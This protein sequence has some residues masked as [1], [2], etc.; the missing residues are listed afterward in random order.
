M[1]QNVQQQNQQPQAQAQVPPPQTKAT[2][3]YV[4]ELEQDVDERAIFQHFNKAG[5]QVSSIRVCRDRDTQKSLGYCYVNFNSHE[6]ASRA[7]D[8][9]NYTPIEGKS[10]PIRIMWKISNPYLRKT[11]V[12]NL[13]INHLDQSIDHR[14]LYD[15]FSTFG[16]ILSLKI[17]MDEKGASKGYGFVQFESKEASEKAKQELNGLLFNNKQVSI[18]D[19]IPRKD[20]SDVDPEKR[21][22]N[23][24]IK[25]LPKDITLDQFKELF[26]KF[27][28]IDSPS[29]RFGEDGQCLG[30]GYVS[31]KSHEAAKAAV[32]DLNDKEVFPIDRIDKPLFCQRFMPK[33]ERIR[34]RSETDS[35]RA[36]RQPR[37]N[38]YV[39]NLD[40]SIDDEGLRAAFKD[41]GEISSVKVMRTDQGLSK[42]FGF[43]CFGS[44]EAAE[45]ALQKMFGVVV[46]GK[47]LYVAHAQPRD[48]RRQQLE[49][50]FAKRSGAY[51]GNMPFPYG[52]FPFPGYNP[53]GPYPRGP[54]AGANN[55]ANIGGP[56]PPRS[57]GAGPNLMNNGPRSFPPLGYPFPA[58]AGYVPGPPMGGR[59]GA[60]R[61]NPGPAYY[62]QTQNP[63]PRGG[64]PQIPRS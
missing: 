33:T 53:Y 47:P 24:Y 13:F 32:D 1:A 38:L 28:E 58:G 60:P 25:N 2:T 37:N 17:A 43:V 11:N 31:F 8:A 39:K 21:F 46:S 41:F 22:T 30:F 48:Q 54:Y 18:E 3:L 40:E 23:L 26:A 59:G 14:S 20:R 45:Q 34:R 62:Q 5:F 64:S 10:K 36:D 19:F 29:V 55:P 51:P 27:G 61:G 9:L 16:S 7:L 15:I 35:T 52:A 44:V 63:K 56:K 42:G 49:Q 12:G 50:Q 4:G 6:E 57:G